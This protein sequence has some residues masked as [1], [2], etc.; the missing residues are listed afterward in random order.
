MSFNSQKVERLVRTKGIKADEVQVLVPFLF[1]ISLAEQVLLEVVT[2]AP[3]LPV[4][5]LL[6]LLMVIVREDHIQ[7]T[8]LARR[9]EVGWHVVGSE[10]YLGAIR[11]VNRLASSLI[12]FSKSLE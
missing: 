9:V 12:S 1:R 3:A 4:V 7:Q 11:G 6:G 5:V 8:C 2:D 10:G